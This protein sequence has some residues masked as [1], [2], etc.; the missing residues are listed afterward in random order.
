MNIYDV[1]VNFTVVAKTQEAADKSITDFLNMS[2]KEF[3][4]E[5]RIN[6]FELM[7]V[8]EEFGSYL[9]QDA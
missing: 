3:A 5:N 1:P 7:D 6:T 4:T 9:E 8:Y 2:F